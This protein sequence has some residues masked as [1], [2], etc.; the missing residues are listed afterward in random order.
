MM[1]I[2]WQLEVYYLNELTSLLRIAFLLICTIILLQL[3]KRNIKV[4]IALKDFFG[5]ITFIIRIRITKIDHS[6]VLET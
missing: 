4:L 2:V 3:D 1:C 5:Y 6:I